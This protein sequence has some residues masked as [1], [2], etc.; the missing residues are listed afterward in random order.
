MRFAFI[1][2]HRHEWLIER[3]CRV[4]QVSARGYRAWTFRPACQRQR[5]DLKILV[6]IREHHA[7]GNAS[8]GRPRASSVWRS[9][10]ICSVI[11]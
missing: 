5:T 6:H 1:H 7:L 10:S 3:L 9:S 11:A 4:L 8:S 2:G